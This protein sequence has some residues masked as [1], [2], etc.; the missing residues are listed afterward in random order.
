MPNMRLSDVYRKERVLAG[1]A[2]SDPESYLL[3][4]HSYFPNNKKKERIANRSFITRH[5]P[6]VIFRFIQKF[7][8]K[9]VKGL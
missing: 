2:E 7:R 9:N 5:L 1:N 6:R 4:V 3:F 8:Q